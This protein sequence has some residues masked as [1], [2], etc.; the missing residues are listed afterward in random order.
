[1]LDKLSPPM[2]MEC[3][4]SCLTKIILSIQTVDISRHHRGLTV[5]YR[6]VNPNSP[7]KSSVSLYILTASAGVEPVSDSRYGDSQYTTRLVVVYI[8][9]RLFF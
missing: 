9:E 5:H 3:R 6:Q 4:R 1:M 2:P 8:S 7:E